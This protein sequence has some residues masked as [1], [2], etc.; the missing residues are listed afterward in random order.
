MTLHSPTLA[1]AQ[2]HMQTVRPADYARS[3][4]AIDG[5]VTGL[6]PYI[7]HG[8]LTLPE[9]LASVAAQHRLDMQH[10]F[11]FQL[12]WREYFQHAWGHRGA[13]ILQSLHA[14]P[15]PDSSYASEVPADIRQARTGI[16]AIDTAVRTL[17]ATGYLHNHAR[18]WL[19]SYVVHIRKVHWR[20][21]ADWMVAHLLDGNLASNH[22]SWQWVAGTGSSKPYLFN[23]ENVAKFAPPDWHSPGSLI[24][25]SYEALDTIARNPLALVE[26]SNVQG[27]DEPALSHTPPDA[28]APDAALVAGRDVWLVHPWALRLP[29]D[30]PA[31]TLCI[32]IYLAEFHS[33]WP[34]S[35]L[36][37]SFVS[38]RMAE[39]TDLRWHAD[40]A[41]LQ[42]ALRG[43]RSVRTVADPHIDLGAIAQVQ[44]APTLFAEV[45]HPCTS[46]S[47][48]WTRSTRSTPHL[49]DLP[50]LA[51]LSAG[52]LFDPPPERDAHDDTHNL[53][54]DSPGDRRPR[55]HRS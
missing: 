41:A 49:H 24:D 5:A 19:A 33:T 48:W 11:V 20:A 18:L 3:R 31:G 38:T 16:P 34:W 21:G 22:L 45:A 2:A 8:L 46:F 39:L 4:N 26:P 29:P 28:T 47:Q 25:T 43:A 6:S 27:T 44:P 23:A 50:G 9:V 1:R 53:P 12:G 52:P 36:R 15:L 13:G 37:W 32:G 54:P 7:T 51:G 42:Q 40:T 10:K 14:G 30:L 35:H 17:Y 55:W